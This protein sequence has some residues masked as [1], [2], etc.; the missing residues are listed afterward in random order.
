M[1]PRNRSK[2]STNRIQ[3]N[4]TLVILIA[5]STGEPWVE[6][7]EAPKGEHYGGT[8]NNSPLIN[9][10]DAATWGQD[11]I[12]W[13]NRTARP[14]AKQREYLACRVATPLEKAIYEDREEV[15]L[16]KTILADYQ[17]AQQGD[18]VD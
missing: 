9:N 18:K 10:N 11:L 15:T 8:Y 2:P 4:H 16:H 14:G 1:S 12:T 13:Y 3:G 5:R 7:L 17:N 6:F